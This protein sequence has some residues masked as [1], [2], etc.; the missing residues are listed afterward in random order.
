MDLSPVIW[1][2]SRRSHNGGQN[3]VE[4]AAIGRSVAVRDSKAS[5]GE[6]LADSSRARWR[7]SRGS[8]TGDNCVEVAG[9]GRAVAVRDSKDPGGGR[10]VFTPGEWNAFAERVKG[11]AYER[12]RL[13]R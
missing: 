12:G 11:G 1:R 10:L 13:L 9:A 5:D 6:R 4:I 3:C 2:K 8:G 7:K